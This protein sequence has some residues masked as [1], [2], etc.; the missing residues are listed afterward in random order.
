MS[1]IYEYVMRCEHVSVKDTILELKFAEGCLTDILSSLKYT[2]NIL[3][4]RSYSISVHSI[5]PYFIHISLK[6]FNNQTYLRL[7]FVLIILVSWF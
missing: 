5:F 1:S 4:L 2:L 3:D 6:Y 7:L